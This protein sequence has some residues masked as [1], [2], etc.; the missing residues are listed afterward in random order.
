MHAKL[1]ES[2]APTVPPAVKV[3]VVV[4][5]AVSRNAA[6]DVVLSFTLQSQPWVAP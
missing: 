4:V 1:I 5:L 2:V 3:T 6:V